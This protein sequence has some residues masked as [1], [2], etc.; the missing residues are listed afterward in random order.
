MNKR[1]YYFKNILFSLVHQG[2]LDSKVAFS[3]ASFLL[4]NSLSFLIWVLASMTFFFAL[5]NALCGAFCGG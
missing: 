5:Y 4:W 1:L 2:F 3:W